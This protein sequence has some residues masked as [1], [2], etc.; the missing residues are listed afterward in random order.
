MQL[1]IWCDWTSSN[2]SEG[3][4]IIFHLDSFS[5]IGQFLA[6][7]LVW[8]AL[9]SQFSTSPPPLRLLTKIKL[10][11]LLKSYFRFICQILSK[12]FKTCQILSKLVKSCQN[13]S[14]L[15]K[16]YQYLSKIVK[17]CQ[18]LKNIVKLA[19]TGSNLSKTVKICQI[20]VTC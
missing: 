4:C 19:K 18:K 12:L 6:S 14:K 13:F 5:K 11:C 10:F 15:F 8:Q 17:M 3:R 16:S 9:E 20:V 1:W 2:K 7:G